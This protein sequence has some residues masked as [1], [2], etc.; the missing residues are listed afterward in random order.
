MRSAA[1]PHRDSRRHGAQNVDPCVW[2]SYC[3]CPVGR[4]H[5]HDPQRS[6]MEIIT[7]VH[8]SYRLLA[9]P[10]VL[11]HRGTSASSKLFSGWLM[12]DF[13]VLAEQSLNKC[14]KQRFAPLS[15]IGHK[16]DVLGVPFSAPPPAG[17]YGRHS[18]RL[19][20]TPPRV[21]G[22]PVAFFTI[23]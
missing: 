7:F 10:D 9:R 1:L 8:K 14:R 20:R 4:N 23:P 21:T 19:R 6:W 15:D 12:L 11:I 18:Q 17:P 2:H 13:R 5:R 22:S 16:V 3:S